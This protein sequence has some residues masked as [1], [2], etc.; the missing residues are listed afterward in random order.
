MPFRPVTNKERQE[1]EKKMVTTK[2]FIRDKE[3]YLNTLQ[4]ELDEGIWCS[5]PRSQ[6]GID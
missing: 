4:N 1:I 5:K 2:R 3:L 6:R